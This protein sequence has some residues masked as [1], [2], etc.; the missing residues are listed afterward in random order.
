MKNVV[1]SLLATICAVVLIPN[2]AEASFDFSLFS[3]RSSPYYSVFE[4]VS[5]EDE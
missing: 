4:E 1:I 2:V 3:N 5:Y